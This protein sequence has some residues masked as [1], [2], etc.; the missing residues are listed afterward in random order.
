MNEKRINHLQS[1][2]VVLEKSIEILE[3]EVKELTEKAKNNTL[4]NIGEYFKKEIEL[5]DAKE[6]VE[7]IKNELSK[8]ND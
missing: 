3:K 1:S 5:F 2:L 4:E 8:V 7:L 6:K